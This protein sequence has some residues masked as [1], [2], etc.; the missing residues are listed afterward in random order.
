MSRKR[1]SGEGWVFEPAGRSEPPPPP[2][3]L[4]PSAQRLALRVESRKK[5]KTV[6]VVS[7]FVLSP[8]DRKALARAL[9]DACGAGGTDGEEAIEIQGDHRETLRAWFA[10]RGWGLRS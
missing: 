6:T 4:P 8:E 1:V 9:K 7:G 5:G 2:R 10:E 3:S